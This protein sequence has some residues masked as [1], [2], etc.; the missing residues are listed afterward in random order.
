SGGRRSLGWRWRRSSQLSTNLRVNE[1]LKA[2]IVAFAQQRG[3]RDARGIE[4]WLRLDAADASAL[5]RFAEELR[6]GQNQLLGLWDWMDEIAA[7]D[8]TAVSVVLEHDAIRAARRREV[9]RSDKLK[10][11]KA[12]LH[13]LRYPQLSAVRDRIARLIAELGLPRS[14]RVVL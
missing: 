7:R 12:A 2:A 10:L 5:L 13:R 1:D 3:F 4:R 8:A 14:V 9:G 11:L 6:L